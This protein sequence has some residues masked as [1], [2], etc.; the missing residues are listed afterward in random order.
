MN[1]AV[2]REMVRLVV[3]LVPVLLLL[4]MVSS[5]P[6]LLILAGRPAPRPASLHL[7]NPFLLLRPPALFATPCG[8][9]LCP[10]SAPPAAPSPAATPRPGP[11]PAQ[12]NCT[13]VAPQL[14][15]PADTV[16]FGEGVINL[17]GECGAGT[18]CC[19]G[20]GAKYRKTETKI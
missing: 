17:R 10:G 20:T 2:S 9:A 16:N 8:R 3:M 4:A 13:C 19:S 15:R 11:P 18:V 6:L 5:K 14:C 1:L 12:H 7:F